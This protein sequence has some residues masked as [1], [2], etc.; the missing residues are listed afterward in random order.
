MSLFDKDEQGE[1]NI[2]F[3]GNLFHGATFYVFMVLLVAGVIFGFKFYI[4]EK[5]TDVLISGSSDVG[6]GDTIKLK[7]STKMLQSSI[8][9][10]IIIEP[11]L[12]VRVG[13]ESPTD[14]SITPLESPTPETVYSI[15][16]NNA[17][18]QFYVPQERIKKEFRSPVFPELKSVYPINEQ[19]DI[20]ISDHITINFD[21]TIKEPFGVEVKIVP[22][23]TGFQHKFNEART[24]LVITPAPKMEK[25]TEYSIEVKI[26]HNHLT[27]ERAAYSGKFTTKPPPPVYYSYH[28]SNTRVRTEERLEEVAP[29]ISEGK[30][31]DI[32]LSSQTMF[33]FEDGKERGAFKISTGKRG[34]DTPKGV[35]KVMGKH[36]RPWSAQYGL[37]MPWFIQFT[38]QGHGIHELPEWPSGYK[39][40]TNHLGIPVSH[41]CVRLGVG[42]AKEVYD[43]ATI[44]ML[45][46]VHR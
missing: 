17:K 12:K 35:F 8:E 7:F 10:S 30:Y 44:G 32:D 19:K 41:G 31:I 15:T 38:S 21:K 39:E 33:T 1:Q 16:I 42:P 3:L 9:E 18:T 43:F 4:Q 2:S 25:K 36:G 13:W 11:A 22:M 28:G 45:I 26:K 46:V 40:G 27:L 14:F 34:M 37:F 29:Q 5:D 6:I 24:Q 23:T 20:D